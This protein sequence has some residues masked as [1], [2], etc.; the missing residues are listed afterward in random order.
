VVN[1]FQVMCD[2]LNMSVEF[3]LT[4]VGTCKK[5]RQFQGQAAIHN[6]VLY[7]FVIEYLFAYFIQISVV[8]IM[9]LHRVPLLR[10]KFRWH[11]KALSLSLS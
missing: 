7:V 8:I 1:F 9:M 11:L 10:K 5:H 2:S 3:E 6:R 4:S